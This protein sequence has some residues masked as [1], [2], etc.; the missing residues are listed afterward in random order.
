MWEGMIYSTLDSGINERRIVDKD[1]KHFVDTWSNSP[2]WNQII[3]RTTYDMH[4]GKIID[5]FVF[6][7]TTNQDDLDKKFPDGVTWIISVMLFRT[8]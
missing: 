3:S 2:G 5:Y 1:Y 7:E 6:N 8:K 4:T